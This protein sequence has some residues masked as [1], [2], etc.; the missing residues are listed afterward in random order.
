MIMQT[1]VCRP[2]FLL[3]VLSLAA[4][5]LF[6]ASPGKAQTGSLASR[7]F[8]TGVDGSGNSQA[9]GTT[10]IH[11]TLF[12]VPSGPSTAL[13]MTPNSLW[14]QN[15]SNVSRWIGPLSNGQSNA[16][17]GVY[18][19]RYSLDLTG[20]DPTT[21]S[22][23]GLWTTDNT[24]E[25]RLNG[26]LETS[27]PNSSFSAFH[28]FALDKD[29]ITG[30]NTLEFWVVNTSISPS[31]LRVEYV[32]GTAAPLGPTVPEP[33]VMALLLSGGI[34]GCRLLWRRQRSR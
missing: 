15:N 29:F 24:V 10:D 25:L 6:W 26:V 28:S 27:L 19:Y 4:G 22:L 13:V 12:S 17:G 7:L 33:G 8:A 21:V 20:F 3:L 18:K 30:L 14:L 2:S 31:G 5:S 16:N 11:Y 34:V 23:S 32:S 1:Y 9:A